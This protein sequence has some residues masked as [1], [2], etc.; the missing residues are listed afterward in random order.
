MADITARL[1]AL[2][3]APKTHVIVTRHSDGTERR[4]ETRSAATAETHAIGERRKVGR[5][6]RH[7]ETNAEYTVVSVE[8]SEIK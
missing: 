2:A 1:A 5:T 4:H 6:F 7:R 8:I 3:A